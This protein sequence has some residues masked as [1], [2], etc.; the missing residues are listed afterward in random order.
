MKFMVALLLFIQT[1]HYSAY[2]REMKKSFIASGKVAFVLT[3]CFCN[4]G[5]YGEG[6]RRERRKGEVE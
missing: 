5:G 3:D 1:I 2:G 4:G 6:S